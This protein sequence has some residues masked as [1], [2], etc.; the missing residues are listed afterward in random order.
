MRLQT[1][2]GRP[3]AELGAGVAR[4]FLSRKLVDCASN[5]TRRLD[6]TTN[7]L[8][9]EAHQQWVTIGRFHRLSPDGK[10]GIDA[11]WRAVEMDTFVLG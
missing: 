7:Y 8:I 5:A 2:V 10:L 3:R 11:R 6:D 9:Q 1:N 4:G